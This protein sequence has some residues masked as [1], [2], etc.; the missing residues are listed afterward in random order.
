MA[1]FL[2][3]VEQSQAPK[4]PEQLQALGIAH[5][6]DRAPV[7]RPN[8]QTGPGNK[9]GVCL[10]RSSDRIGFFPD[11]QRWMRMRKATEQ[12]SAVW[13]GV[14]LDSLPTP[15]E[16]RT[17]HALRGTPVRLFD[18]RDW[19]IPVAIAVN[20]E[21]G[22]A[23]AVPRSLALNDDGEWISGDA[24]PRY[25]PLWKAAQQFWDTLHGVTPD[26]SGEVRLAFN[27]VF[28]AAITVLATNYRLSNVEVAMLGLLDDQGNVAQEILKA[29]V[30]LPAYLRWVKKNLEQATSVG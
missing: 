29:C 13:C 9:A 12:Q 24:K 2:Y 14:W 22:A 5:A 4:T 16:L 18:D 19:E 30:E 7:S 27:T 3:F 1:D 8:T 25:E 11:Q 21:R 26:A 6:F 20:D 17:S 28:D 10:S 15:D 23:M